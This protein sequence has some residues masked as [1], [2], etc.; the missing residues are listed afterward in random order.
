MSHS[1]NFSQLSTW[2]TLLV[3]G[4]AFCMIDD[5]F[6]E[7]PSMDA[8]DQSPRSANNRDVQY[9]SLRRPQLP[10]FDH[11]V[12]AIGHPD[13]AYRGPSKLDTAF[14]SRPFERSSLPTPPSA[15]GHRSSWLMGSI[16]DEASYEQQSAILEDHEIISPAP[17]RRASL[18][19]PTE[20]RP[21][22]RL[23]RAYSS[24]NVNDACTDRVNWQRGRVIYEDNIPGKG[25]CYVYDDGTICPKEINGDA[26]NPE[27]GVTKAGE[28]S[29]I[30]RFTLC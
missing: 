1:Q 24:T 5:E 25:L 16:N 9:N 13:L 11:F 14:V 3:Q 29:R 30:K 8:H 18:V 15:N 10:N 28:L 22:P 20:L 21:H 17:R 19:L 23:G 12:R 2:F 26:V 4:S 27:W 7:S 6:W